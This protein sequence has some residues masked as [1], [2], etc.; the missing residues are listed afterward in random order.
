MK[1]N[2]VLGLGLIA[3]LAIAAPTPAHASCSALSQAVT[4]G[5]GTWIAGCADANPV[6]FWTYAISGP[7]ANNSAGQDGVCEAG[8]PAQNGI[9]AACLAEAGTAGDGNVTVQYDWGAA[10]PGSA[11]CAS[12]TGASQGGDPI[13]VQVVANDGKSAIVN[14]GYDIGLGGY[15]V[16]YAFPLNTDTGLPGNAQCS[17][18]NAPIVSSVSAGPSPSVSNVCVHVNPTAMFSDCDPGSAGPFTGTCGSGVKP[19]TAPGRLYLRTAPCGSSPDA[20]LSTGWT[21]APVQPNP[22]GDACN[23]ATQPTTAGQCNFIGATGNIAGVETLAVAGSLQIQNA[24]AANDRVKIDKASFVQGKLIVGF[25]TINETSIVGFN[26]YVGSTKL[27]SGLVQAKGTGS[28]TYSYEAARSDVKANRT[29]TVEAV[30]SDGSVEKSAPV[31][32]K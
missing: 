2:L 27:N 32:L 26:V 1:K 8:A 6:G 20:R 11:G 12:P 23:G 15:L 24:A 4:H 3:L 18:D 17:L 21:L 28:N 5:F 13:I 19:A 29:V 9:G 14:V 16:D 30:K 25:S 22:A 7:A 31:S 10:N